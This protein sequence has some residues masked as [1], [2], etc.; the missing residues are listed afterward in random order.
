[1]L[2][3]TTSIR[4]NLLFALKIKI[5]QTIKY[6]I[7]RLKNGV[8]GKNGKRNT[9]NNKE[10]QS[11]ISLPYILPETMNRRPIS[12]IISMINRSIK[13]SKNPKPASIH[14]PKRFNG[15]AIIKN[16]STKSAINNGLSMTF[17]KSLFA[18][19]H[20]FDITS[21]MAD[22]LNGPVVL[23]SLQIPPWSNRSAVRRKIA[24]L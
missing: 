7:G 17:I 16:I 24:H 9:I 3:R 8:I 20:C 11:A 21:A 12:K 22:F 19:N 5:T 4:C 14:P 23:H 10:T 15:K 13:R 6:D 2:F 1:M 18:K